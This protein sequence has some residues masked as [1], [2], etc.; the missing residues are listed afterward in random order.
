MYFLY[1][2]SN[3]ASYLQDVDSDEYEI[4]PEDIVLADDYKENGNKLM[5]EEKF[6]EALECYEK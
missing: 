3:S 4:P 6:K 5:R 2:L 1:P